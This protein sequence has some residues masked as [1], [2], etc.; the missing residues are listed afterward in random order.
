[1]G[2]AGLIEQF[3]FIADNIIQF[4]GQ[5]HIS[6]NSIGDFCQC[7]CVCHILA[8]TIDVRIEINKLSKL[9][10]LVIG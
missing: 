10:G 8:A 2:E 1:M 7:N 9:S 3:L 4:V 5:I 6:Y